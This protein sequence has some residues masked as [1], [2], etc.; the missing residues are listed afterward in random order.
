MFQIQIK[1]WKQKY[2]RIVWVIFSL[3]GG[4][5]VTYTKPSSK[6][7]LNFIKSFKVPLFP[8]Q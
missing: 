3:Y 4:Y 8:P 7:Q 5:Y 2:K 6:I 1:V